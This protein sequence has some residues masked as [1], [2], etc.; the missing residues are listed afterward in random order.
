MCCCSK[1]PVRGEKTSDPRTGCVGDYYSAGFGRYLWQVSL[2]GLVNFRLAFGNYRNG[3]LFFR[4]RPSSAPPPNHLVPVFSCEKAL[5][6]KKIIKIEGLGLGWVVW[7]CQDMSGVSGLVRGVRT[8]QGC[9]DLSGVSGLVR[10][11]QGCQDLSGVPGLVRGVRTCQGCQDLS[12][13]SGLVRVVRTCQGCQDLSG[14]TSIP[15]VMNPKSCMV[16]FVS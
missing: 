2:A 15:C 12:G 3:L 9:Q 10:T 5:N 13:V 4:L 11:C 14:P 16:S 7:T 8:C 1:Q 6:I